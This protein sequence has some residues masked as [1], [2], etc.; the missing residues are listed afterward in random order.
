MGANTY[1]KRQLLYEIVGILT[2]VVESTGELA[3]PIC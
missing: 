2:H 1:V 3:Y